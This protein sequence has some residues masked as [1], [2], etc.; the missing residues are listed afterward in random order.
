MGTV[1]NLL[2]GLAGILDGYESIGDQKIYADC[3]KALGLR[4]KMACFSFFATVALMM[5]IFI[6]SRNKCKRG[7]GRMLVP[8]HIISRAAARWRV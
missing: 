6:S 2:K 1:E 3:A 7:S 4:H 8:W 5:D